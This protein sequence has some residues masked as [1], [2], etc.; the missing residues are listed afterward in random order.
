[1]TTFKT[2]VKSEKKKKTRYT[3]CLNGDGVWE[4][5]GDGISQNAIV[6]ELSEGIFVEILNNGDTFIYKGIKGDEDYQEID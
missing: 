2:L 3:H 4:G 6:V 1:M 5:T